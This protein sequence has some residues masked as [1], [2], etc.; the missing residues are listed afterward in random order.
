[1]P[2]IPTI[3]VLGTGYVGLTT[4]ALCAA[5][6]IKTYVVDPNNNRL[7][8]VRQGK[9]FF[10]EA[11]LDPLIANAVQNG[12]L[13]PT[14]S[15]VES[16]PHSDIIFSAVGTPDN[17][18]GSSNLQFVFAA[19][20]E[21]AQHMQADAIYVQKSTVPVGTGKKILQAFAAAG[22]HN[23]YVS[24]PEFLREGT[25]LLDSLWFDR[26]VVGGGNPAVLERVM[27]I[28][29]TI[30]QARND[31]AKR[32]SLTPPSPLPAGTYTTVTLESAEMI[33][34]VSNA[35]LALKIS[36]SN[37]VAL[38]ADKA[39]A[40]IAEVLVTVGADH[41]IGTAFLSA[42][43]GYGGGCFP[44]D[45]SGLIAAGLEQG[46]RLNIMEAA[47]EVNDAMPGYVVEKLQDALG[48]ALEKQ[49]IAVL[50]L[51]FKAGT[52]DCRRSGPIAIA[53]MLATRGA[54]V[55]AFDPQANEEARPAL[56]PA[57]TVTR[58]A[59]G[60]LRGTDAV[61]IA[62]DW[63][64]FLNLPAKAYKDVMN[65]TIFVDAMNRFSIETITDAGLHYIG[66]GRGKT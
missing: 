30:E 24:N 53:N 5:A 20:A 37:S 64:E 40:D 50:G 63:P 62:T 2:K 57:I 7:S 4:A 23:A 17:P 16:V 48:G 56:Q 3:T 52:S 42:G 41:R 39:G 36:F 35:F 33:K 55:T 65:G 31:I 15:Y 14:A 58:T 21:A 10:Y 61:I 1:M 8:S 60:A 27:G 28:Y 19:A 47:Q 32:A 45:V 44:K 22:I 49:R 38:L 25:A 11:G 43:R 66:V 26:V 6:G 59:A 46:V 18:D 29:R 34:V 13:I 54:H 12:M 51:A 9:S